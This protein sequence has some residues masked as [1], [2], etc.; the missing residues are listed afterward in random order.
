[1]IR[2][3]GFEQGKN[4]VRK[5][6][7]SLYGLKQSPRAWFDRFSKEVKRL[8]YRQSQADHTMFIKHT[9]SINDKRSTSKQNVVARSSAEV[10]YRAMAHGVC[11]VIWVRRIY[12]ELGLEFDGPIQLYCDN[13]SA[14][15]IALNPVQHDRTKHVEVDRHFIK[16]KIERKIIKIPHVPTRQQ[17]TDIL[18]KG[19]SEKQY[20]V[21]LSKLGLINIYRPA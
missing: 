5:L 15:N 2:P 13:Q 11:E 20:N 12:E 6:Q 8:G 10:E 7:K 4:Q 21:F 19:L 16:E 18:T 17:L 14:I 9:G 3:P 1:M